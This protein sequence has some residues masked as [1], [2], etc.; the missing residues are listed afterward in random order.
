MPA[1]ISNTSFTPD[2][3]QFTPELD[4]CN[5]DSMSCLPSDASQASSSPPPGVTVEPVGVTGDLGARELVA[6]HDASGGSPDC[7]LEAR[8]AVLSCSAAAAA[9][10]ASVAAS[11]TVLGAVGGVGVTLVAGATCGRDVA[12]LDNCENGL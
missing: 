3:S 2:F 8:N 1:S 7:S 9:A 4:A 5:P 11:V 10:V 12:L 6:R